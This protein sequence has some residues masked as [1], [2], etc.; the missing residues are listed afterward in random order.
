VSLG[1]SVGYAGGWSHILYGVSDGHQDRALHDLRLP[2][3]VTAQ[4]LPDKD[5]C[6]WFVHASIADLALFVASP[7]GGT[8]VAQQQLTWS[9]FVTPGLQAGFRFGS[10]RIPLVIGVD[11]SWVPRLTPSGQ[12]ANSRPA[13]FGSAASSGSTSRSSISIDRALPSA[14][15]WQVL[16]RR[17]ELGRVAARGPHP[18]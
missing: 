3:G 6:P 2:I 12:S 5:H 16:H 10:A 4:R 17:D 9:D 1:A 8:Q 13:C 14:S 15:G 11:A 18:R 7:I